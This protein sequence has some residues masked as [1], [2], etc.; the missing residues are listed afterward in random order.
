MT[1]LPLHPAGKTLLEADNHHNQDRHHQ[2]AQPEIDPD[3]RAVKGGV[4]DWNVG[5]QELQNDHGRG[6]TEDP[7]IG[8]EPQ[9]KDG[10]RQ[11]AAI[12]KVKEFRHHEEIDGNRPRLP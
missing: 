4:H 3:G 6:T 1:S 7:R 8:K 12:E 11:R 9:G 10:F 2:D 5:E